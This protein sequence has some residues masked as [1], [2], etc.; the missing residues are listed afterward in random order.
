MT[1]PQRSAEA[2]AARSGRRNS[3]PAEAAAEVADAEEGQA[4]VRGDPAE[5]A[6]HQHREARATAMCTACCQARI[7]AGERTAIRNAAASSSTAA[8]TTQPPDPA[9]VLGERAAD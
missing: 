1:S 8:T 3:S 4:V 2:D 6:D 9:V 5:E 7:R